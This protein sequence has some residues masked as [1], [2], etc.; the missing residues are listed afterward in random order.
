MWAW[1]QPERECDLEQ[2]LVAVVEALQ[3]SHKRF[4]F[5]GTYLK[6]Y[7]AGREFIS[8]AH[9][10]GGEQGRPELSSSKCGASGLDAK[11]ASRLR[12]RIELDVRALFS[13]GSDDRRSTDRAARITAA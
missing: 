6:E 8:V 5:S 13:A 1:A 7:A 3:Q 2:E 12:V 10:E 9:S 11:W 4:T